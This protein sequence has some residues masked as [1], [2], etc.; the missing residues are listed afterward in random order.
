[1]NIRFKKITQYILVL[2]ILLTSVQCFAFGL[3]EKVVFSSENPAKSRKVINELNLFPKT[4]I[5]VKN[6]IYHL[7]DIFLF[8]QTIP[9]DG[10]K[11]FGVFGYIQIKEKKF[12]RFFYKSGSHGIFRVAPFISY[13]SGL[14]VYGDEAS[15]ISWYS[16][17]IGEGSLAVPPKVQSYLAKQISTNSEPRLN[18]SI[19]HIADLIA[20]YNENVEKMEGEATED[21]LARST[22]LFKKF[23]EKQDKLMAQEVSFISNILKAPNLEE[24]EFIY[25]DKKRKDTFATPASIGF[26]N[27]QN[28]PN[29]K[30][31]LV[32]AFRYKIEHY[33]EVDGL[34]F[35]SRNDVISYFVLKNEENKIWIPSMSILGDNSIITT[36]GVPSKCIDYD[37]TYFIMPLWERSKYIHPDYRSEKKIPRERK[38]QSSWD[39]LKNIEIIKNYYIELELTIPSDT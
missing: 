22:E 20:S 5:K 23:K 29:Y 11:R 14:N 9:S 33:G 26:I 3:D 34:V 12:F 32:E 2:T 38:Y 16:K 10:R 19:L 28:L 17:G 27:S 18:I 8:D 21:W 24:K 4:Q 13:Y 7:T 31:G 15:S 6:A 30:T 1:M 39:Y 25:K 36:Y 37:Q 35:N